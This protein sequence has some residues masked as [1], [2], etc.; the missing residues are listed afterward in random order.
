MGQTYDSRLRRSKSLRISDHFILQAV[1]CVG[2]RRRLAQCPYCDAHHDALVGTVEQAGRRTSH[3]VPITTDGHQL[4]VDAY[5]G[6]HLRILT[7]Q[8]CGADVDPTA[9]HS[10]LAFVLD[11]AAPDQ[12]HLLPARED[13]EEDCW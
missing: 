5:D 4:A 12:Q 9:H 2:T 7:C 11:H 1:A 6:S 3:N 10:P 13:D 8:S